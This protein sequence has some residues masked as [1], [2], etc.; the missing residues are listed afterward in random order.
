M[1]IFDGA[2]RLWAIFD[3]MNPDTIAL[4]MND[5]RAK[6]FLAEKAEMEKYISMYEGAGIEITEDRKEAFWHLTFLKLNLMLMNL[7]FPLLMAVI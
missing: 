6:F 4:E 1:M 2:K 5:D 7:E 3:S